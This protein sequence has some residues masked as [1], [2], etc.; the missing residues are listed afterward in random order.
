MKTETLTQILEFSEKTF[1]EGEHL[2]VSNSL[3]RIYE[4]KDNNDFIKY[5]EPIEFF[6]E[7]SD[8]PYISITHVKKVN[9]EFIY[10]FCLLNYENLEGDLDILK[11]SI[12]IFI[13]THCVEFLE[14]NSYFEVFNIENFVKRNNVLSNVGVS[15]SENKTDILNEFYEYFVNDILPNILDLKNKSENIL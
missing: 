3:K 9:S 2:E 15:I 14:S 5:E 10:N 12:L 7:N 11:K 4:I 13:K 1:S 8:F 6:H